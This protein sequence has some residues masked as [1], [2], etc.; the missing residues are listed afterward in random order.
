MKDVVIVNTCLQNRLP[1]CIV[2]AFMFSSVFHC[3]YALIHPLCA[4]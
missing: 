1:V 3:F 2:A 4:A